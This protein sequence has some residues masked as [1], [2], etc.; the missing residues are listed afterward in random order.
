MTLVLQMGGLHCYSS[1]YHLWHITATCSQRTPSYKGA[2]AA[3]AVSGPSG[4]PLAPIGGRLLG[5]CDH[6]TVPAALDK[7]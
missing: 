7:G 6:G 4:S 2:V 5:V 1:L 3:C